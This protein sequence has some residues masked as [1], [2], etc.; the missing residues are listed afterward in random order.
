MTET[1]SSPTLIAQ[2]KQILSELPNAKWYQYEPVNADNAVAGAKLAFGS[3]V[4][5]VYHF[6]KAERILTIDADILCGNPRYQHDFSKGRQVGHGEG[7]GEAHGMNRLY[8]IETTLTLAG[9]KADHRLAVK[10]S[11]VVEITKAIAKAVGVAGTASTYANKWV[12]EMAKDLVEHKGKSA[13]IAGDNQPPIVHALVHSINSTLGN[14]GETVVYTEPLAADGDKLQIEGLKELVADMNAGKVK[15]LMILGG[16]PVYNTP[17]DAKFT[18]ELM[19][20]DSKLPFRVHLGQMIDE[21]GEL[22]HWHINAKHFLEMWSD[23][24]AYDG[25]ATIVQPL[26]EPLYDGKS[27]HQIIQLF[28]KEN[29]EKKELDIIR[30][31]WKENGVADEKRG[32]KRF[33][34]V[35][36]LIRLFPRKLLLLVMRF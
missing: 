14:V 32:A 30:D 26:I 9:G 24:R 3:A 34:M 19:L 7:H 36:W 22:C 13:V 2:F 31:Y 16:N 23:G 18:R 8:A 1:I 12:E 21:T 35:L 33:M 25:T 6:D 5:S 28:L 20:D 27:V 29:Y 11:E 17:A 10:P 4:S 15:T